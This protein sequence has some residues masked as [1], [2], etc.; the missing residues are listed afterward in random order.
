M[1]VWFEKGHLP[2][3]DSLYL[4]DLRICPSSTDNSLIWLQDATEMQP[5]N[6]LTHFK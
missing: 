2:A 6:V 1:F 4:A 3:C 5:E